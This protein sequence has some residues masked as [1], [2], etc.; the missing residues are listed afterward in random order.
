MESRLRE[1]LGEPTD[2]SQTG[3][4]TD[5]LIR[6]ERDMILQAL[7]SMDGSLGKAAILLGLSRHALRYRMNRLSLGSA[8]T[9]DEEAESGTSSPIR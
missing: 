1:V 6:F 8:G 2:R 4:L 7:N 9:V 3:S 5:E